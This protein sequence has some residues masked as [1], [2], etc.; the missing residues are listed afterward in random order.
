M[1]YFSGG[2][3]PAY[4]ETVAMS[5]LQKAQTSHAS[6]NLTIR[7]RFL[8]HAEMYLKVCPTRRIGTR[9]LV[10]DQDIETVEEGVGR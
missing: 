9:G 3:A 2:A 10:C 1:E 6:Q 5:A 8:H 4:A 7:R